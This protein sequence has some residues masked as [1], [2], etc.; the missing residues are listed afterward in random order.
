[1]ASVRGIER[2]EDESIGSICS[3]RRVPDVL[4][5]TVVPPNK[6][7]VAVYFAPRAL[8][9]LYRD[10]IG[11]GAAVVALKSARLEICGRWQMAPARILTANGSVIGPHRVE[12]C[13]LSA[14]TGNVLS[15]AVAWM[16]GPH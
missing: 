16:A 7:H 8:K 4:V 2:T 1:M 14:M 15:Y 6:L 12:R 11:T 10:S 13:Q 9:D 5:E 3:S